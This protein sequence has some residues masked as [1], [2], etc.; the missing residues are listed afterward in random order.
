MVMEVVGG[1]ELLIEAVGF[2]GGCVSVGGLRNAVLS[3]VILLY[4]RFG[5][6]SKYKISGKAS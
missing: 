1:E 2:G 5:C 6:P 3:H 4:S